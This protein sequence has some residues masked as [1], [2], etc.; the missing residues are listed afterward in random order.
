[1]ETLSL[2]TYLEPLSEFVVSHDE[3]NA[4]SQSFHN[5]YSKIM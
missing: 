2:V 3:I 5:N 4:D 1:M